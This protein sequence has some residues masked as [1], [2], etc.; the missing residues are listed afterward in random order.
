[1]IRAAIYVTILSVTGAASVAAQD[2]KSH[3]E[4]VFTDQKCALC[5]SVGGKGNTKGPLDPQTRS[6]PG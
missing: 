6:R 5:H 4:R 3:G 1:M 2:A